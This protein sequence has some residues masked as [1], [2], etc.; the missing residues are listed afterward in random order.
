[1]EE[2]VNKALSGDKEAFSIIFLELQNDLYRIALSKTGNKED[3]L[4]AIQETIIIVYKNMYQLKSKESFKYWVIKILVNE[5]YKIHNKKINTNVIPIQEARFDENSQIDNKQ[6]I[7]ELESNLEFKELLTC[8]NEKEKII[9]ILYYQ[10]EYTTKEIS[11][12]LDMKENTIKSIIKR[13][14]AKIKNNLKGDNY[15]RLYG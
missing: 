10:N 11:K 2:L 13:S 9:L 5:C 7:N 12:I 15:E 4:D 3:A 6:C 14:K 1:M 8:L